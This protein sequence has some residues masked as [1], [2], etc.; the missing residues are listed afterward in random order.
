MADFSF[1]LTLH[2]VQEK[3]GSRHAQRARSRESTAPVFIV[4]QNSSRMQIPQ[5]TK[6]ANKSSSLQTQWRVDVDNIQSW[7]T[8]CIIVAHCPWPLPKRTAVAHTRKSP[9]LSEHKMG[10]CF[11]PIFQ[12]AHSSPVTHC[13]KKPDRERDSGKRSSS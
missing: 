6:E 4:D 13:S 2:R 5:S 8:N 12:L 7:K 1:N 9:Q 11:T 3:R 10:C